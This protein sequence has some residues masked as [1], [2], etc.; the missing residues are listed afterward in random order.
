MGLRSGSSHLSASAA[1]P[2]TCYAARD[3]AP[4]ARAVNKAVLLPERVGHREGNYQ[5][6]G[7]R[8]LWKTAHRAGIDIGRNQT[9]SLMRAA[10]ITGATR[11]KRVKTA[12]PDPASVRP[13]DL[14][15]WE[16]AATAPN[17]LSVTDITFVPERGASRMSASLSTSSRGGSWGVGVRRM[18]APRWC[19]TRSRWRGGR[20][21]AITRICGFRAMQGR[22]SR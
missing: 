20:G 14:V 10:G 11:S 21:A 7:V 13:P 15:K 3:R 19:L 9:G 18:C 4:L 8:K 17:R 12:R 22:N 16:F 5:F 2:S 6:Y 1:D